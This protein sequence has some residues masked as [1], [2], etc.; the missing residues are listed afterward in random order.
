MSSP[1][2]RRLPD[3]RRRTGRR[4]Q[5]PLAPGPAI[6]FVIASHPDDFRDGQIMRHVRS[7][8]MHRH[9]E[10]GGLSPSN[11]AQRH[12]SNTPSTSA[13][14]TPSPTRAVFDGVLE[15]DGFLSP[16][17]RRPR[18]T[19][20]D[21]GIHGYIMPALAADMRTLITSLTST[22][23]ASSAQSAPPTFEDAHEFPFP[24]SNIQAYATLED[25][26]NQYISSTCFFC[27]GMNAQLSKRQAVDRKPDPQ[28]MHSI[29]SD[30]LS[31]LSHVSVTCVY[32]DQAEGL[33]IDSQFTL[34]ARAEV[35]DIIHSH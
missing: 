17:P 27:H 20:R 15:N 6:Q 35:K 19:T 14:R 13:T 5:P 3:R 9:R 8:V 34:H 21:S 22:I 2:N 10:Q 25:M 18:G 7:H 26:R 29:C 33:L 16:E 12:R 31:F 11:G 4:R 30:P 32:Q 24:T 1:T 23:S 28:W